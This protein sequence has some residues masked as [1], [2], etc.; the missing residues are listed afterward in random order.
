MGMRRRPQK[1]N[2]HTGGKTWI[3]ASQESFQPQT[4]MAGLEKLTPAAPLKPLD[5]K[6]TFQRDER[7]H[8][9]TQVINRLTKVEKQNHKVTAVIFALT[10]SAFIFLL[11]RGQPFPQNRLV[12]SDSG[13]CC[14]DLH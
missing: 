13:Y 14:G 8:R 2:L 4:G 9:V 3:R 1:T 10:I 5:T 12:S 7:L 6:T 11:N